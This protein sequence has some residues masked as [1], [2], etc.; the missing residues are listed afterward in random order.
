M[1]YSPSQLRELIAAA[2]KADKT[3]ILTLCI[4]FTPLILKEAHYPRVI[5]ALHEDA[6]NITW[7]IFLKFIYKYN[8]QDYR[9]LPGLLQCHLRYE[10]LHRVMSQQHSAKESSLEDDTLSLE[11]SPMDNVASSLAL[12][13][14]INKLSPKERLVIQCCY[15]E[16]LT[17][18]AAAQR[19]HCSVR[20]IRR[21]HK[22]AL[23][24]LRE[25]LA[26]L[27]Q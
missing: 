1:R 14:E 18:E 9:H 2:Q 20:S 17:Q 23:N 27:S 19:L 11:H 10:L 7:E 25:R 13:Q 4:A 22:R 3:A 16:E 6:V 8:G 12:K 26:S 24:K 5:D 21:Y 15:A